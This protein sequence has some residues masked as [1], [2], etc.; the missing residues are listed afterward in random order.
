MKNGKQH[1]DSPGV[2]E[3]NFYVVCWLSCFKI[4]L[5]YNKI[6]GSITFPTVLVENKSDRIII[7][8]KGGFTTHVL[9]LS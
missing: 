5:R 6:I 1:L 7:I 2:L 3:D 4:N 9:K 8:W